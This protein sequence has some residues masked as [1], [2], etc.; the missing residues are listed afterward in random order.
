MPSCPFLCVKIFPRK[1]SSFK[2]FPSR[3]ALKHIERMKKGWWKGWKAA[4]LFFYDSSAC[5]ERSFHEDSFHNFHAHMSARVEP[6]AQW[7]K[8]LKRLPLKSGC[9][10]TRQS[11]R[12]ALVVNVCELKNQISPF[13][14]TLF[15]P[16]AHYSIGSSLWKWE[17]MKGKAMKSLRVKLFNNKKVNEDNGKSN[18]CITKHF[19]LCVLQAESL[20]L[21]WWKEEK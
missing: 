6:K 14:Q 16:V 7:G 12:L 4:L 15:F 1:F 11:A 5:F 20:L 10:W 9:F 19:T 8:F 2:V 13:S 18:F 17:R 3:L 21:R